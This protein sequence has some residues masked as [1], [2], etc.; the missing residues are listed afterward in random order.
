MTLGKQ[1]PPRTWTP[2]KERVWQIQFSLLPQIHLI[3]QVLNLFFI[4]QQC[5]PSFNYHGHSRGPFL[6][7][8][9]RC[10]L[11]NYHIYHFQLL[12]G[13]SSQYQRFRRSERDGGG[14]KEG[15]RFREERF[16]RFACM[17][18]SPLYVITTD[19]SYVIHWTIKKEQTNI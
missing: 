6:I 2:T 4:K 9:T 1:L 17:G 11:D 3:Y 8:F 19:F 14:G 10:S 15:D 5:F 7:E 13:N 12:L 16:A 18:G